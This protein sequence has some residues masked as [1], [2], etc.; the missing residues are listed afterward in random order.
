[1]LQT[2]G[3]PSKFLSFPDENHWTLKPENSRVWHA[4]V[5]SSTRRPLRDNLSMR[6]PV[7]AFWHVHMLMVILGS[8]L[9]S[10]NTAGSQTLRQTVVAVEDT[11]LF[12]KLL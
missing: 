6:A 5:V 7:R 1:V 8:L 4:E 12:E 10:T 9:G 3:V 11:S 2:R